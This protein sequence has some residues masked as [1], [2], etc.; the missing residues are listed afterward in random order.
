MW[1]KV[2]F[3]VLTKFTVW[4]K[5]WFTVLIKFTAWFNVCSAK[6][7]LSSPEGAWQRQVFKNV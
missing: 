2:W 3:T 6:G 1:R 5:V 4:G 7:Y